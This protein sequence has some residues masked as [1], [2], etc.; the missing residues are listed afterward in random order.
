MVFPAFGIVYSQGLGAF[1][2][3]DPRQRRHDADR[4]AL[5]FFLIAIISLI[6]STIQN[7]MFASTAATLTAKL[8]CL[9][10]RAIL[11]QDSEFYRTCVVYQPIP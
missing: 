10:F 9:S 2:S 4:V 11:R 1:S 7:Y 3:L 8:R 5:W 6:T